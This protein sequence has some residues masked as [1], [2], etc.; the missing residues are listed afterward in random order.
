M[1]VDAGA[2]VE[3]ARAGLAP[4]VPTCSPTRRSRTSR[5]S[6]TRSSGSSE[7]QARGWDV[8][9][10]AAAFVPTNRLD[11]SRCAA[12]LRR[13]VVLQDVRLPDRRRRPAR[14]PPRPSS[15]LQRPWFAGGTI[16]VASVQA[17]RHYLAPGAAAFEDG[18]RQLPDDP[19]GRV[20]PAPHRVDRAST[21][22]TPRVGCLTG[23]LIDALR[24]AAPRQRR[25]AGAR[26]TDRPTRIAR[27]GTLALNF[28]DRDGRHHRSPPDRAAGEPRTDLAAHRLLLQ[29]R[30][31]ARPRS[32][33]RRAS[34][35]PCFLRST[36]PHD[37]RRVPHAASTA[38][39][40]A[41]CACRSAW[42][43]TSPMYARCA[44]SRASSWTGTTAR[45]T[46]PGGALT[47]DAVRPG[48][49]GEARCRWRWRR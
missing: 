46:D 32:A 6:S 40:P 21:R 9:L 34:S 28:Y 22:S 24:R 12:R 42:R 47:M 11:L 14:A 45:K 29:P 15:K 20:R 44:T 31:P 7:A 25:A 5:A 4:R 2:L 10:D 16:T 18:T 30:A 48:R 23:W 41:P 19:G 37:V 27:G 43:A 17:D 38:R 26:C 35:T 8:L 39:A 3:R 33:C 36:R 49:G 13:A 1:R